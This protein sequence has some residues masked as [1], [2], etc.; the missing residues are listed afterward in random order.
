MRRI[1]IG[2][3]AALFLAVGGTIAGLAAAVAA[4]DGW[5][6]LSHN[7]TFRLG[8]AIFAIGAV[9]GL[10]DIL[11][12]TSSDLVPETH[13][14][15]LRDDV[16]WLGSAVSSNIQ[17]DIPDRRRSAL[18]RHFKK[19]KGFLKALRSWEK[20]TNKHETGNAAFESAFAERALG[21]G[22]VAPPFNA[23]HITDT[24]RATTYARAQ[25]DQLSVPFQPIKWAGFPNGFIAP[26]GVSGPG[27]V[28]LPMNPGESDDDWRIRV[29]RHTEKIEMLNLEVQGWDLTKSMTAEWTAVVR[30]REALLPL[31]ELA[32]EREVFRMK[33][34]C[35]VC[36]DNRR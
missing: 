22:I 28:N 29:T 11:L 30:A 7:G 6:K 12:S 1:T 20:A 17:W 35:P 2:K 15:Y 36:K 19:P 9:L 32:K 16:G 18:F 4:S 13:R 8:I 25:A 31:V 24:I 26:Q 3:V 21:L 34:R 5:H 23:Q 10:S 27:W 33:R 14:K